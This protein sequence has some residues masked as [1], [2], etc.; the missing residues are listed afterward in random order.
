MN[1]I[2]EIPEVR[3]LD[4]PS[5]LI[6]IPNQIDVPV[7]TRIMR[8][9]DT[10]EFRRLSTISQLGV[11]S[12]VY[13]AANHNR[14]E[15]SLGVYRMSLLFLRRLAYQTRFT[16]TVSVH[17][18]TLLLL[19]AL[20]HDIGHWPFCHPIEDLGLNAIPSHEDFGSEYIRSEN[21]ANCL[22]EDWNV[23]PDEVIDLIQKRHDSKAGSILASILSGPID[24][25]KMD[26][27]YRDSLHAG[28]PYGQNFDSARLIQSL[29]L[30]ED[31]TKLAITHKGKTAAEL[32]VFARYV[33]FSEVYWHHAVRSA[34]AMFQRAFYLWFRRNLQQ[35][36]F[37]ERVDLLLRLNEAD[38]VSALAL[39]EDATSP[40][41]EL[42]SK[43][44]LDSLFG[45][46][47]KLFKRI[48]NFSTFDGEDIYRAV[49]QRPYDWI[50]ACSSQLASRLSAAAGI[51][52]GPNQV[53]IDAPP[54]GLE[55]QFNVDVFYE[56]ENRYR[57]L[58]HVSPVVETLARQQ[59]DDFVKQVRIFVDPK[60]LSA[61]NALPIDQLIEN[62]IADVEA[63]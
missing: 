38:M 36:N 44:L 60:I 40:N 28:V 4:G 51:P 14:F 50:V 7:T 27:L 6:R 10:R 63:G 39:D 15:H 5:G 41:G 11:V 59:F 35:P 49:A 47:R 52:I 53:I 23:E 57:K 19:A 43:E 54:V 30:N 20:L 16:E 58:G 2:L 56:K 26:Y 62:A 34:T 21:I 48:A 12:F 24:I 8:L 29:C 17:E 55:V 22:R 33:M 13:P 45:S 32:M 18:A 31:A 1:S 37:A 9:V 46:D 25:D 3:A 42:G 61:I